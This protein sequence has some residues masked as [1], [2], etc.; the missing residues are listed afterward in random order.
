M[1]NKEDFWFWWN[2]RYNIEFCLASFICIFICIILSPF[3]IIYSLFQ[4]INKN[5]KGVQSEQRSN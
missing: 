3:I 1:K 5:K 2:I 4:L